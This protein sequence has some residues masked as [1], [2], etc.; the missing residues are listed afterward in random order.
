M[1]IYNI[2]NVYIM[3]ETA[4]SIIGSVSAFALVDREKQELYMANFKKLLTGDLDQK[5][6]EL[7]F[8]EEAE[9]PSQVLLHQAW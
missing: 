9:D 8:Q 5:L 1:N 3:K 2:L 6:F 7:K 4:R